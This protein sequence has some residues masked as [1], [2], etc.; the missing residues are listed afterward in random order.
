MVFRSLRGINDDKWYKMQ[1]IFQNNS[2]HKTLK[3]YIFTRRVDCY[4]LRPLIS[5]S[6]GVWMCQ[7]T[8]TKSQ[9]VVIE[10][11]S[12]LTPRR[13]CCT[14]F[15]SNAR[16]YHCQNRVQCGTV[17]TRPLFCRIILTAMWDALWDSCVFHPS[18]SCA[19]CNIVLK[20]IALSRHMHLI[21]TNCHE[22]LVTGEDISL[23]PQPLSNIP[24]NLQYQVIRC[25]PIQEFL[26]RPSALLKAFVW[27]MF[28]D[29]V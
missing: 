3:G 1:N 19:K 11:F 7:V 27:H 8:G 24:W 4:A 9:H 10:Q 14:Q 6:H 23:P 15:D 16:T 20:W 2:T 25:S 5:T 17:K 12:S 21:A 29:Y 18:H 22:M 13:S 26:A 28:L